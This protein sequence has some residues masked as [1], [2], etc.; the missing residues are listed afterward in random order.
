VTFLLCYKAC[1]IG[2]S[3]QPLSPY[4]DIPGNNYEDKESCLPDFRAYGFCNLAKYRS[5]LKDKF[6]VW[7]T[8]QF[9]FHTTCHNQDRA[10][11]FYTSASDLY[12]FQ[13]RQ[14]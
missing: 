2:C 5:I 1:P 3:G 8:T 14:F 4:C 12:P 7:D 13:K 9:Y 10:W 11:C 6:Q